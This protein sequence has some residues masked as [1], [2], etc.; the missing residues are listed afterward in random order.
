MEEGQKS[1]ISSTWNIH[2]LRQLK[3]GQNEQQVEEEKRKQK[4]GIKGV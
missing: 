1:R 2:Y 4:N 3:N